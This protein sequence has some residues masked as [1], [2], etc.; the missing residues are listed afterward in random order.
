MKFTTGSVVV[1]LYDSIERLPYQRYKHY[2]RYIMMTVVDGDIGT[3]QRTIGQ[4]QTAI[5][6]DNKQ[7]A[8]SACSNLL[9]SI[10]NAIEGIQP[11]HLAFCALVAKI[12]GED[13]GMLPIQDIEERLSQIKDITVE[14][15]EAAHNAVKKKL[16]LEWSALF[17]KKDNAITDLYMFNLKRK[18]V[19][20]AKLHKT[21]AAHTRISKLADEMYKMTQPRDIAQKEIDYVS[22]SADTEILVQQQKGINIDTCTTLTFYRALDQLEEAGRK[23]KKKR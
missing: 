20:M 8:Y 9:N 11:S 16:K 19:Q 13:V 10:N 14:Q 22:G 23:A 12:D 7:A 5:A 2:N 15:M 18:I 1:H 3:A 21:A 6:K 4:I 17:P